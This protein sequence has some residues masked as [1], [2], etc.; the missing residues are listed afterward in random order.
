MYN[1]ILERQLQP[2][3]IRLEGIKSDKAV[4]AGNEVQLKVRKKK[5]GRNQGSK[6]EKPGTTPSNKQLISGRWKNRL[7]KCLVYDRTYTT[8]INNLGDVLQPHKVKSQSND[9]YSRQKEI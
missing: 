7:R 4:T 8:N 1:E 5:G 9:K 6:G 2:D 3:K